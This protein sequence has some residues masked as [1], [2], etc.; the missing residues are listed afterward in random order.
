MYVYTHIY[1][2]YIL[3]YIISCYIVGWLQLILYHIIL[4]HTIS[5][6]IIC[7][8]LHCTTLLLYTPGNLG[9]RRL[10]D[11]V[12]TNGVFTEGPHFTTFCNIV[13]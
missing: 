2:Y 11:V 10:P 9:C 12:G 8:S 13:F 7:M 3:L 4:Y 1:M 6:Y 5:S